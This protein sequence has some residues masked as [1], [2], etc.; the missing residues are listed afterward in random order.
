MKRRKSI[1]F[2]GWDWT[3]L[4]QLELIA[5]NW[6]EA[7]K[8]LKLE[9][10]QS[11]EDAEV[12]YCI[13]SYLVDAIYMEEAKEKKQVCKYVRRFLDVLAKQDKAWGRDEYLIYLAIAKTADETMLGWVRSNLESMW[14]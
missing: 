1:K 12:A 4:K 13:K 7:P 9:K 11:K 5:S 10:G 14:T 3:E 2:K 6:P 8:D